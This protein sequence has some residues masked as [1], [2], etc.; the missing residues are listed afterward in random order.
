MQIYLHLGMGFSVRR[1]DG[2]WQ[3]ASF[4]AYAWSI[5]LGDLI[6]YA[7]VMM[8]EGLYVSGGVF[9]FEVKY[10]A[11]ERGELN[12]SFGQTGGRVDRCHGIGMRV[13]CVR[14]LC[15]IAFMVIAVE[16]KRF[17]FRVIVRNAVELPHGELHSRWFV[18]LRRLN[19]LRRPPIRDSVFR[20]VGAG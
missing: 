5:L 12:I 7:W 19:D 17:L 20:D 15:E 3:S 6:A 8:E 14:E 16:R 2:T 11:E 13:P 10:G 9:E 1:R 18:R 4:I